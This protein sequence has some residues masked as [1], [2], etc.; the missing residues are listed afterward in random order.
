MTF[1]DVLSKSRTSN[2]LISDRT[3]SRT[4]AK[5][6]FF[7]LFDFEDDM[8]GGVV[9]LSLRGRGDSGSSMEL[10]STFAPSSFSS[11]FCSTE[12]ESR[13]GSVL[14]FS[15]AKLSRFLLL[16]LVTITK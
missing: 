4:M 2:F 5:G 1:F 15:W 7:R 11:K 10:L 6:S 12:F 14:K 3:R 13:E 8:E 9:G 16:S